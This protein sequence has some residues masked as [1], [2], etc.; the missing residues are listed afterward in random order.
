MP[1]LMQST[2]K[3]LEETL[4]QFCN[5]AVPENQQSL[6]RMGSLQGA[7]AANLKARNCVIIQ[8]HISGG[9]VNPRLHACC[10]AM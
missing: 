7:K 10:Q 8:M 1:P 2:S 4:S 6:S 9:G 3:K 5:P